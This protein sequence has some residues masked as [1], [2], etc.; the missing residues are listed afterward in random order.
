MLKHFWK[1]FQW[2]KPELIEEYE[3]DFGYHLTVAFMQSFQLKSVY[4]SW[5]GF[6]PS[7]VVLNIIAELFS[8]YG[9][10]LIDYIKP[11]PFSMHFKVATC[12]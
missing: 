7:Y 8:F 2:Y 9:I 6:K 12:P 4:V 1:P 3:V 10:E 5:N 11:K